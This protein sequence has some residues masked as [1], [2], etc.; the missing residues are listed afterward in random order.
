MEKKGIR[1][2][3]AD[4]LFLACAYFIATSYVIPQTSSML[5]GWDSPTITPAELAAAKWA[6]DYL[7]QQS[8]FACDLFACEMIT[9]VGYK[10]GSV[11]GAWELSDRPNERYMDNERSFITESAEEAHRLMAR[12]KIQYVIVADRQGF[13]A[14]G[15]KR[16]AIAK[17]FDSAYFEK[18]YDKGG[19]HIFRVK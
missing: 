16:P 6:N 14:Y 10:I 2:L 9:A 5:S 15:W 1:G 12:W 11:G 13:Y 4:A 19:A 8:L 18:V 3:A 7:P 17:F